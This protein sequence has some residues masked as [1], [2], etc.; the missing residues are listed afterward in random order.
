MLRFDVS[1]ESGTIMHGEY[2]EQSNGG[3]CVSGTRI[4]LDSVV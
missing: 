3:Y 2:I 1:I 4:S